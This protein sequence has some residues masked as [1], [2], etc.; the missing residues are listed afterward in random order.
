MEG[1]FPTSV[2]VQFTGLVTL[3]QPAPRPGVV[4][5]GLYA[6]V[7]SPFATH[8]DF[9]TLETSADGTRV[10]WIAVSH[11]VC[12]ALLH[13]HFFSV[14]VSIPISNRWFAATVP[15]PVSSG[16]PHTLTIDGVCFDADGFGGTS[17][18]ALGGFSFLDSN[19]TRCNHQWPA[20]ITADADGDGW[21]DA[22]EQ[23]L[24]S[25]PDLPDRTPEHKLVPTTTLYGADSC[26]DS[27]DNHGDGPTDGG[28]LGC[29]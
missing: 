19:L 15:G 21:S 23:R 28:D 11:L 24:G 18:H 16:H 1:T 12:G 5:P 9:F 26:H 20:T 13:E 4:L 3:L 14:S 6:G 29:Q 22:A 10:T 27:G 17:E 2:E 7:Y 25:R 8:R